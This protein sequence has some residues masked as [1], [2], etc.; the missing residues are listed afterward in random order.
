MFRRGVSVILHVSDL[1]AST[2]FYEYVL[3]FRFDGYIDEDGNMVTDW[4]DATN[5][6]AAELH[7][8]DTQ[9]TLQL[10][11]SGEVNG[12]SVEHT[13]E[14]INI[15]TF[16]RQVVERGAGATELAVQPWGRK[17]FYVM[18]ADGHAWTFYKTLQSP[19]FGH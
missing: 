13:L 17:E 16:Y 4:D 2:E 5:P 1:K 7:A 6:Q 8:G 14:V 18:D 15:D 9:I 12:N 19:T 11:E 3:S 10:D